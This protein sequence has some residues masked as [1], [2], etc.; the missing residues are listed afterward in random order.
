[1]AQGWDRRKLRYF[2]SGRGARG[3]GRRSQHQE[4]FL[5]N[6]ESLILFLWKKEESF[7]FFFML[8]MF[9][10]GK[11]LSKIL[12]FYQERILLLIVKGRFFFFFFWKE[13]SQPA[14]CCI[15]SFRVEK[16]FVLF[17]K[18][19]KKRKI[20]RP[21]FRSGKKKKTIKKRGACLPALFLC[22]FVFSPW[23]IY[24]YGVFLSDVHVVVVVVVFSK[25]RFSRNR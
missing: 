9:K 10:K 1:M 16:L 23:P 3:S 2:G 19:E 14:V 11:S 7:F 13:C 21:S 15:R 17:V 4:V 25:I 8:M 20:G 24:R 6:R 5:L 12:F 22:V 18:K